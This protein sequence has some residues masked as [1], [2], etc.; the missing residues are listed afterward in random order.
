MPKPV[1]SGART[2]R[3]LSLKTKL[4]LTM[5]S[6]TLLSVSALFM[7]HLYSQQQLLA[8]VKEYTEDLSTAIDIAQ[9]PAAPE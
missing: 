8:K 7:L 6:L 5:L 1:V 9:E 2:L 3:D 4:L